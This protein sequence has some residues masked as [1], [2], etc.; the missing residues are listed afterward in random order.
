MLSEV[1]LLIIGLDVLQT[2]MHGTIEMNLPNSSLE[3]NAAAWTC[4]A[5]TEV[6]GQPRPYHKRWRAIATFDMY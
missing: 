2:C 3:F 1:S 5:A 4:T 6:S